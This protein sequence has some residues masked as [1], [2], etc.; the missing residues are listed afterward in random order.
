MAV[1]GLYKIFQRAVRGTVAMARQFILTINFAT[2]N[3][4]INMTLSTYCYYQKRRELI[5]SFCH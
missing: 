3:K 2:T 4:K 1:T 5:I